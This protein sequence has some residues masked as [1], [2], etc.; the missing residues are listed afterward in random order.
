MKRLLVI[1][2]LLIGFISFAQ[3]PSPSIVP[4]TFGDKVVLAKQYF[5]VDSGFIFP[6]RD[7]G[8]RPSKPMLVYWQHASVD[9]A[10]WYYN[11]VKWQKIG[12]ITVPIYAGSGL[13]KQADSNYIRLGGTVTVDPSLTISNQSLRYNVSKQ[14]AALSQNGNGSVNTY[15]GVTDINNPDNETPTLFLPNATLSTLNVIGSGTD[16]ITNTTRFGSSNL[17]LL[18]FDYS[19]KPSN[20]TLKITNSNYTL[21]SNLAAVSSL[22]SFGTTDTTKFADLVNWM[23]DSLEGIRSQVQ[24]PN[25]GKINKFTD[26][27]IYNPYL[28]DTVRST[29]Y[30]IGNRTGIEVPELTG[31]YVDTGVA[32]NQLGVLDSVVFNSSLIYTRN[33][34]TATAAYSLGVDAN[35]KQV[36]FVGSTDNYAFTTLTDAATITWN[37]ATSNNAKVTLGGN[38]TLSISNAIT[39]KSYT[40]YVYQD[41]TGSRTLTLPANS[42]VPIGF[43]SGTTINLTS[44]PSA[45][46]V[47]TVQYDGTNYNW[48]PVNNMQ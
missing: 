36:K 11:M 17:A 8:F 35:G 25:R 26:F 44:T 45:Y 27:K 42:K 33:T 12:T 31:T 48:F 13:T 6:K 37:M 28:L 30:K 14:G 10:L 2:F 19:S 29:N 43:G 22:V 3:V 47:I 38:R 24:L 41:A 16:T 20:D 9:T 1:C 40:I 21:K 46:D 34:P 5:Q 39:G 15:T 4:K 32:I 23:H 18:R 7:T